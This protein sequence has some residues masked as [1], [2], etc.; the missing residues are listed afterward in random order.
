M[1]NPLRPMLGCF[2]PVLGWWD[3][4]LGAAA[5]VEDAVATVRSHRLTKAQNQKLAATERAAALVKARQGCTHLPPCPSATAPDRT[6]AAEV[7]ADEVCVYLCNGIV[8]SIKAP[9]YPPST[10]LPEKEATP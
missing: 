3:D 8:L 1:K 6:K 2:R 5:V 9:D 10:V 7:Y 4:V